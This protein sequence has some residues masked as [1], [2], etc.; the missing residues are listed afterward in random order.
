M[1][2][3][4]KLN[5][6]EIFDKKVTMI[7]Y[8]EFGFLALSQTVIHSVTS[9]SHYCNAP[10]EKMGAKLIH[11]IK[12]KR[13]SQEKNIDYCNNVLIY[14]GYVNVDLD[15]IIYEDMGNGMRKSRY[16]CF[17]SRYLADI[18]EALKG[19]KLIFEY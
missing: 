9:K 16:T 3:F 6:A 10:D 5:N 1:N 14:D 11:T 12:G 2:L 18:K 7:T 17:D 4:E 8:G 15:I 13:K 19:E